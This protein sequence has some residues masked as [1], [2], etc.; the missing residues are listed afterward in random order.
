MAWNVPLSSLTKEEIS[1]LIKQEDLKQVS[2]SDKPVAWCQLGLR[3]FYESERRRSLDFRPLYH[4]VLGLAWDANEWRFPGQDVEF[5]IFNRSLRW[6]DWK[7]TPAG[8]KW[9]E[10]RGSAV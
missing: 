1:W 3:M 2:G 5:P 6:T 4:S 8:R 7:V 10:S 9:L